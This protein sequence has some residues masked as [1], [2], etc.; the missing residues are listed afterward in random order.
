LTESLV[1]ERTAGGPI[2]HT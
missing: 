2:S 1:I